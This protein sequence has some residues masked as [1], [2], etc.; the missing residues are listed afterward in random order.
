MVD[1]EKLGSPGFWGSFKIP[2]FAFAVVALILL[3][4]NTAEGAEFIYAQM[5]A[6]YALGASIISYG[7]QLF[8]STWRNRYPEERDLPW[9]AQISAMI[10]HLLWFFWYFLPAVS[11]FEGNDPLT[12]TTAFAFGLITFN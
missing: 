9:W 5:V 7:H 8:Y 10:L 3:F 2:A 6:N 1:W 4:R 11:V 12:E